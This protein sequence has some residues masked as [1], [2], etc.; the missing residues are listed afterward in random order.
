MTMPR[1]AAASLN[2]H[3]KVYKRYLVEFMTFRDNVAYEADYAFTEEQLGA[4]QPEE[5]TEWLSMKAFGM[6]NPGSNDNPQLGR[7]SS[8]EQYKKLL[9]FFMPNK[10]HQWDDL[11]RRGNPTRSSV[12][13]NLV[14]RVKKQ[15]CHKQGKESQACRNMVSSEFEQVIE[16]TMR[17]N[18]Q[19]N[20]YLY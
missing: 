19:Q 4:I 9:S 8:L 10:L 7:S 12:V 2:T 13:N 16:I 17:D 20:R 3:E 11:T 14:R 1:Y 5:V 15:E 18:N 6:Q